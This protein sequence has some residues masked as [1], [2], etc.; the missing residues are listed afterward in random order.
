MQHVD[1]VVNLQLRERY[2]DRMARLQKADMKCFEE[3]YTFACPKFISPVA[4]DYDG[5]PE[6]YNKVSPLLT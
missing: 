5:L 6:N 3:L 1:E 4:P 2:A